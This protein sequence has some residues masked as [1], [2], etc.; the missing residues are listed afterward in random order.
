[1][2]NSSIL[3]NIIN[4]NVNIMKLIFFGDSICY[5]QFISPHNTFVN[6]ISTYLDNKITNLWLSNPSVSGNTTR[7]AL[8]RMPYDLQAH[9]IDVFYTQFG[10]NDCNYWESDNGVSRVSPS[11]FKENLIEIINRSKVFGSTINFLGTNH[12]TTLTN[13]FKGL[14]ISYQES[15]ETYNDI[16]RNIGDKLNIEV[17]DHELIWKTKNIEIKKHLLPDGIHLNKLGH[18][19]YFDTFKIFFKKHLKI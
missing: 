12:P 17:V 7:M 16:I 4:I 5:G 10:M 14:K 2:K 3:L 18:E 1:M 19:L 9:G 8:E 11:A 6:K 13:N 15:N